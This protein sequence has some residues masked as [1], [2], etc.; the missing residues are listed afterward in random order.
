MT[1]AEI[2]PGLPAQ[3]TTAGPLK[4]RQPR[5]VGMDRQTVLAEP[6]RQYVQHAQGIF[7]MAKP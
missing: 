7:G 3:G 4:R 1:P 2:P 5:L 6:L